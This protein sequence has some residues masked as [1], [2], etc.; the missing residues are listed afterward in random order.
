MRALGREATV[1][2]RIYIVGGASAVLLGWRD[3]TVDVDL[4]IIPDRDELLRAIP[5]LKES[6]QL[7]VE[8]ASPDDFIPPLPGWEDRSPFIAREGKLSFHHYDF[9]AQALAKIE[10]GHDIDRRDVQEMLAA[11]LVK[12][13]RLRDLFAAIEPELYRY[14]AV[15]PDHFRRAVD[16]IVPLQ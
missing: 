15:D 2:G 4:K 16:A 5:R 7:N 9:Y 14:P 12:P 1:E 6:L 10:R 3:S 8:L 13:A 11:G